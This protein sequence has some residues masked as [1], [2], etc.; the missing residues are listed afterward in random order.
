M[1]TQLL[2]RSVDTQLTTG[3]T[4]A[5]VG[6]DTATYNFATMPGNLPKKYGNTVYIWQTPTSS[7]P[8]N[9]K[10]LNHN[11]VRVDQPDGSDV[12]SSLQI[13]NLPYL[14][15]YA[16]GDS[17]SRVCSTA[18]IPASGKDFSYVSPGVSRV[19][20][21]STSQTFQ[22]QLP[23]GM[24]PGEDGDWAGLWEGQDT[25]VLYDK[26]VKPKRHLQVKSEKHTDQETFTD[27]VLERGTEYIIGYFKGGFSS[28]D[29]DRRGLACSVS[30]TQEA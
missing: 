10:P 7:V 9:A 30:W 18:F 5:N 28:S 12:F 20:I 15:A 19:G 8:R 26:D 17:V 27:V 16:V 2:D 23:Q 21:G 3:L 6:G 11:P 29:P 4:I 13:G 14:I 24:L 25:G 1:A 22:Y